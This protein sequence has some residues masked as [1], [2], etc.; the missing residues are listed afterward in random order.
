ML[1]EGITTAGAAAITYHHVAYPLLLSALARRARGA[2]PAS[3]PPQDLPSMTVIVPAHNEAKVIA[4]KM[5]NLAALDYP[6]G[7]LRVVVACDGCTDETVE[8]VR[9]HAHLLED[10][11]RFD[12]VVSTNNVGKVLVI[13]AQIAAATSEVVAL[14]D[15][16]AML[17]SDALVRAALHFADP[18]VGVVCPTYRLETPGSVGEQAYWNYQTRI[19]AAEAVVGAPMGA[20]GAFYVFRRA[21][22]TALPADTINDDFMLPITIIM[23]GKRGLYDASICAVERETT[24]PQQEYHRRLR[25]GAGNLQQFVNV[26]KTPR[27]LP[28]GAL[29]VFLSGKGMRVAIPYLTLLAGAAILTGALLGDPLFILLASIGALA[30]VTAGYAIANRQVALPK[31]VVCLGYIVEGYFASFVGSLRY[32]AGKERRPWSRTTVRSSAANDLDDM[33]YIPAVVVQSKRILD[34]GLALCALLVLALLYVPI[35][36]AIK[37]T[38]PGPVLYRQL[39]VGRSTK[40]ATRLFY[41]TKFRTMRSDAEKASGA[42]WASKNDPRITRIGNFLRKTRLDELPQCIN[43]LKGEMSVVGPRPE[44]PSFFNRLEDAIPYYS[45]RTFGLLPG[46]TGLAQVNQAYDQSIEDVRNKVLYDHAYAA[47]LSQWRHWLRAD[48]GIIFKTFTVMA[49]GKGQ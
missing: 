7:K 27:R 38:S 9:A 11:C 37:L 25:I 2:T 45:E 39:R 22:W 28:R 4:E 41:L 18:N 43:V 32:I 36:L 33:E 3:D 14:T 21:S 23:N 1:L 48:I 5:V 34:I 13:N 42:I 20:H 35:A 17:Q 26:M 12:I 6:N 30:S 16:S 29:F 47:H 24:E 19:K 10:K 44:R 8:I 49:L 31:P 46:I 15:A 40:S